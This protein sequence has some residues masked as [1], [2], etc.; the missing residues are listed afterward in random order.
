ML[1]D[2]TSVEWLGGHRIRL[3]FS[4]L[5]S[6]EVDLAPHLDFE[7][8]F[9]VLRDPVR[10]G[11]VTLDTEAGTIRWPNGADVDPLVLWHWTTGQPLPHWAQLRRG[12]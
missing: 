7:G 12:T 1:V 10:F 8:V 6:G 9:A 4:D 3:T 11:E 5:R 2:V